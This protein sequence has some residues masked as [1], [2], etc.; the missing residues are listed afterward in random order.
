[1]K[2]TTYGDDQVITVKLEGALTD[3]WV[4]ELLLCWHEATVMELKRCRRIDLT[5]VTFV[6]EAG[7]ALLA[8]LHRDGAEL[9]AD[10][11]LTRAIVEEITAIG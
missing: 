11:L 7:I 10:G 8:L 5:G 4:K 9:V 6:D 2:I 3:G 1:M